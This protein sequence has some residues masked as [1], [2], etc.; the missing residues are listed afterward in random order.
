VSDPRSDIEA[1]VHGLPKAELHVHLQGA[2]SV[3]TVLGLARRHP[4]AGVPTDEAALRAFYSFTDFAHF[5]DVYISVNRLVRSA[6]D[7]RALVTGLGRDLAA[8]NVRYAEVTVTPDSHLQMGI[9]PDAVADA[10]T[11][12]RADVLARHGVELAWVFDIPGEL[13]LE[14]GLRTID[15][16]ERYRPEH[17]VGFG[18]GGPETGIGRPQFADVF[19]R[20]RDL[21]LASVPH[22]GETTGPQTVRDAVE[23][24]GAV[25]IGHGIS[26]AADPELL[27]MLVE[28]DVVLEVCPTS[29]VRTRA[30]ARLEDHPFPALRAAG[31]RVT[32]NTDDP[33]MFNTDLNREYLVAHCV[34]GLDAAALA[35][36]AGEAVRASFAGEATRQRLLAEIEAYVAASHL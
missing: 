6:D 9:A 8:V 1:F 19:R 10:L 30:V 3:P 5:I 27:A 22:A 11:L 12:G 18:L 32:L 16:V 17:S 36:L 4:D 26:A 33:G 35:G 34:F 15:W 31:V 24:L 21:G 13:G 29:N 20:A 28:R 14:S 23:V 7:V 2:A 25:R